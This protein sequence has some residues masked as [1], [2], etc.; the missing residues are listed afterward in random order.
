[1]TAKPKRRLVSE[2]KYRAGGYASSVCSRGVPWYCPRTILQSSK[3][4]GILTRRKDQVRRSSLERTP[5]FSDL[6]VGLVGAIFLAAA[7]CIG[8]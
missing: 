3:Y 6:A 1:M 5:S 4:A 8:R 2:K 7:F